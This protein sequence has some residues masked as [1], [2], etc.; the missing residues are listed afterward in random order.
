M[1]A[2]VECA[3]RSATLDDDLIWEVNP[4]AKEIGRTRRQTHYL[5]ETGKLPA[6]KIGGRWCASRSALGQF[7]AKQ[8]SG[9]AA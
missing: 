9:Q 2:I 8:L 4:I 7:F 5:L 6:C 3:E 1:N